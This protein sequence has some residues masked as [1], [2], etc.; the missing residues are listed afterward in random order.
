MSP[1]YYSAI[2]L[3]NIV[4]SLSIIEEG[5]DYSL[6]LKE[7]SAGSDVNDYNLEIGYGFSSIQ[8]N[9]SSSLL[10]ILNIGKGLSKSSSGLSY[11][12]VSS[13]EIGFTL[14]QI[15]TSSNIYKNCYLFGSVFLAVDGSNTILTTALSKP[16]SLPLGIDPLIICKDININEAIDMM[17]LSSE[18]YTSSGY[19]NELELYKF[20]LDIDYYDGDTKSARLSMYLIDNRKTRGVLPYADEDLSFSFINILNQN[21]INNQRIYDKTKSNIKSIVSDWVSLSSWDPSFV[22]YW[23]TPGNV[24]PTNL[25]NFLQTELGIIV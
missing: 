11:I 5:V 10:K 12:P 4:S 17:N 25:K 19:V 9:N 6:S 18:I 15:I 2:L 14:Q 22:G 3:D 8:S 7:H 23:T 21:Y 1:N 13:N 20:I 24:L 16:A